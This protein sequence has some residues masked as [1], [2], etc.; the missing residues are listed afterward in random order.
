MD[1]SPGNLRLEVWGKSSRETI[2][3]LVMG[4]GLSAT[5]LSE[6]TLPSLWEPGLEDSFIFLTRPQI[7]A[8]LSNYA[9]FYEYF[10]DL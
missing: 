9:V 1:S 7:Y 6:G 4:E 3:W 8:V 10:Q 2:H 5:A